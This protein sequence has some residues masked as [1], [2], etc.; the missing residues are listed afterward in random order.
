MARKL[1]ITRMRLLMSSACKRP[2]GQVHAQGS[3]IGHPKVADAHCSASS[4]SSTAHQFLLC[5]SAPGTEALTRLGRHLA[6]LPLPPAA[7]KLLLYGVLFRCLDPLLT[8]AC[9]QAYRR[10]TV[11][12]AAGAHA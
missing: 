12:G 11:A 4:V 6:A 2:D 1:V 3:R 8:I 10:V 7:G 5:R 9:G